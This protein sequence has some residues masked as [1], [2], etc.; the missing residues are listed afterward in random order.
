MSASILFIDSDHAKIF[1]LHPGKMESAELKKT[2]HHTHHQAS[3][4]NHEHEHQFFHEVAT[5]LK[6][7]T[8]LLIVGP[9]LAK[10]KFKTHLETHHHHDLAKSV[11]GVET[12]DHP[13]DA[14]IIAVGRNFFKSYDVFH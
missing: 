2:G 4:S 5:Q 3:E 9:G 1:S 13:T 10:A 6:N 8:E 7:V 12:V 11:V 14:Q